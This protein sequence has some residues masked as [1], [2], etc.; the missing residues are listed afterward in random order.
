V[1]Q[2]S[3][4]RP[5]YSWAARERGHTKGPSSGVY[6]G[7]QLSISFGPRRVLLPR[8]TVSAPPARAAFPPCCTRLPSAPLRCLHAA[9][10]S[11]YHVRTLFA[12]LWPEVGQRVD[13]R[14]SLRQP[15]PYMPCLNVC[16]KDQGRQQLFFRFTGSSA[17]ARTG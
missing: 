12:S 10:R 9:S 13:H 16:S 1:R 5:K 4:G 15:Y 2:E 8:M 6:C 11:I 14:Q 3:A 7:E 17:L